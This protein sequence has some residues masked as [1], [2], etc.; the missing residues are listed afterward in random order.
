MLLLIIFWSMCFCMF[1]A[2]WLSGLVM[3]RRCS[4]AVLILRLLVLQ[5][6]ACQKVSGRGE[7]EID[8][9]SAGNCRSQR[10]WSSKH[11]YRYM[12]SCR[13]TSQLMLD[14]NLVQFDDQTE[15]V[16]ID[17]SIPFLR[18]EAAARNASMHHQSILEGT[19]NICIHLLNSQEA[20]K[21]V[22]SSD[23]PR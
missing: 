23:P 20:M 21:I 18:T 14:G 11:P 4:F 13:G 7:T 16:N 9:D 8:Q 3:L 1:V 10:S 15:F 22:R 17:R 6:L 19:S 2:S 5:L 12:L